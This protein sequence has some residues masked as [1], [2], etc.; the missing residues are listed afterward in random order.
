MYGD[1]IISVLLYQFYDSKVMKAIEMQILKSSKFVSNGNENL[2][3]VSM[4]YVYEAARE[5]E[6]SL[7][8]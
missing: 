8:D 1:R 4:F 6:R 2:D 5:T 3:V 7:K